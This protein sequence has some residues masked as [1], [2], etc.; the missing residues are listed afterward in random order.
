MPELTYQQAGE[1]KARVSELLPD[2][3]VIDVERAP[4]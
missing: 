2:V 1:I 3:A 4:G